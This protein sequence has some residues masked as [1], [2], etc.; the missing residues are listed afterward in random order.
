MPEEREQRLVRQR[1]RCS[2]GSVELEKLL[3]K[4]V[5]GWQDKE[6]SVEV[7]LEES[8]RNNEVSGWQGYGKMKGQR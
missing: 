3:S 4:E 8:Q 6:N 1:E 7:E 5:R 2:V